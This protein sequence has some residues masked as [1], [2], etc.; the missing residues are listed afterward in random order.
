MGGCLASADGV[1]GCVEARAEARV[2]AAVD[3]AQTGAVLP[4][5]RSAPAAVWAGA[6]RGYRRRTLHGAAKM[7]G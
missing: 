3:H 4:L 5:C 6:R 7:N 2:A 1:N